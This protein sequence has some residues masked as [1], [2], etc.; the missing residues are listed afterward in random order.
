MRLPASASI[1][2]SVSF[3]HWLFTPAL[4]YSPSPEIGF[5]FIGAG[6]RIRSAL[7]PTWIGP[8][9]RFAI[10][11]NGDRCAIEQTTD[12][13]PHSLAVMKT[14]LSFLVA[15]GLSLLAGLAAIGC[16]PV[17]RYA[18]LRPAPVWPAHV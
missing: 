12:T 6:S 4:K 7:D 5:Q 9:H 16:T 10:A 17:M 2:A 8:S 14:L 13:G 18:P 11:H 3:G 1:W 15:F